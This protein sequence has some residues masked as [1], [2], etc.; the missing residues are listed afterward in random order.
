MASLRF[1]VHVVAPVGARAGA[2]AS[3]CAV[4]RPRAER[5]VS[6]SATPLV[7]AVLAVLLLAAAP[8][9]A[10]PEG[11][12]TWAIHVTLAPTRFDPAEMPGVITPFMSPY[13]DLKLK[14]K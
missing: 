8:A 9:G 14:A 5:S 10:A 7:V 6:M 11:Q 4:T 12:P 3:G 1:G 13:E 2:R